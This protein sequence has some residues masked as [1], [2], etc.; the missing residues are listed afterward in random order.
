MKAVLTTLFNDFRLVTEN[1]RQIYE[2]WYTY[3]SYKN[4]FSSNLSTWDVERSFNKPLKN[5]RKK[6][7][8]F[9]LKSEFFLEKP[10]ILDFFSGHVKNSFWKSFR[11]KLPKSEIL[12]ILVWNHEQKRSFQ[13]ILCPTKCS[14][15]EASGIFNNPDKWFLPEGRKIAQ[16]AKKLDKNSIGEKNFSVFSYEHV[17]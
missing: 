16:I 13:R 15:G 7:E 3:F 6:V 14:F 8:L 2:K 17:R 5:F 12:S 9:L 4:C 1:F 10:M 11:T